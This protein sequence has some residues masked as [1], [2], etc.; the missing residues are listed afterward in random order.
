MMDTAD[1]VTADASHLPV[2]DKETSDVDLF[3]E[4]RKLARDDARWIAVNAEVGRRAAAFDFERV[5]ISL[6][7]GNAF[8]GSISRVVTKVPSYR[9]PTAAVTIV[10]GTFLMLWNPRF[11]HRISVGSD[12]I[13]FG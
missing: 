4:L 10:N 9:L 1:H 3:E 5:C 13:T 7:M 11:M 2:I 8:Y 6:L 12:G